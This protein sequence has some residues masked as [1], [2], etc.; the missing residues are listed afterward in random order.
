MRNKRALG[1]FLFGLGGQL[2]IIASLSMTEV[3]VLIAAPCLFFREWPYMRRTGVSFV[4]VLSVTVVFGCLLS[5]IA[6]HTDVQYVIRGLAT[7]V[8]LP[9]AIIM[10][11]WLL[12]MDMNGF[13]WLLIGSFISGIVCVFVFQK[14]VDVATWTKVGNGQDAVEG[15]V[16]GQLFWISQIGAAMRIPYVGWY[17]QCPL[18]YSVI[19]PMF[20]VLFALFS[21]TSGRAR[22]LSALAAVVLICL[23]RKHRASMR[24]IGQHFLLLSMLG[25]LLIGMY[26][27]GYSFAARNGL[28]KAGAVRKYELQTHGND[29]IGRLL[30]GGRADSFAG[31]LACVR[32]PILGYGPWAFDNNDFMA[33]FLTKYGDY[34]DFRNIQMMQRLAY[35]SGDVSLRLIPCHSHITMFW[36][37]YGIMGLLFWLYIIFVAVRYLKEDCWAV[38]QWF[39][40]LAAGVPGLC[41][42]IIFNPLLSRVGTMI[43]VVAFFFARAVRQGRLQLPYQMQLEIFKAENNAK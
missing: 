33:E 32:K 4:F 36:L 15:I 22:S 7:V 3:F 1:W 29:S 2:Q 17:L 38:P 19:A 28:L 35:R 37:W 8:I 9:C 12:R 39:A 34:D 23:G 30:L 26:K 20:L 40:W 18:A 13:K 41:W 10:G 27:I 16:N 5:S 14:A 11:H 24:M 42:T 21:S 25:I 43:I 6:N 31:L